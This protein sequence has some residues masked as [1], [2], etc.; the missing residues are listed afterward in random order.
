MLFKSCTS[1]V[2]ARVI[3][4]RSIH[5]VNDI[6]WIPGRLGGAGSTVVSTVPGS[7]HI[8]YSAW[9]ECFTASPDSRHCRQLLLT[10]FKVICGCPLQPSPDVT[11]MINTPRCSPFSGTTENLAPPFAW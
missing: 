4:P 11:H 10:L 1:V 7:V 3:I 9:F 8:V 2:L 5:H 6:R